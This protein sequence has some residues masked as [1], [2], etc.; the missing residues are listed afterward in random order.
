MLIA[1]LN[2][3]VTSLSQTLLLT[4]PV[5]V[6]LQ[7]AVLRPIGT[8]FLKNRILLSTPQAMVKLL[9]KNNDQPHSVF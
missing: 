1:E 4:V 7:T 5:N 3:E 8:E 6:T 9:V 2:V